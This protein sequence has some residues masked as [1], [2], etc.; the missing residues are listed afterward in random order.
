MHCFSH[1][2]TEATGVCRVCGRAVCGACARVAPL[3]LTCSPA[4]EERQRTYDTVIDFSSR[5]VAYQRGARA[6][7]YSVFLG[8]VGLIMMGVGLLPAVRYGVPPNWLPLLFG[9]FCLG[10]GVVLFRAMRRI[11]RAPADGAGR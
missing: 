5:S 8:G 3:A 10:F 1:P 9:I 2:G 11:A 6:P 7:L 4:C